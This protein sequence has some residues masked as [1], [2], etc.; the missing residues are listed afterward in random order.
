ME[1]PEVRTSLCHAEHVALVP[2]ILPHQ[3]ALPTQARGVS[4]DLRSVPRLDA[5]PRAG[6][7]LRAGQRNRLPGPGAIRGGAGATAVGRGGLVAGAA[8]TASLSGPCHVTA[9]ARVPWLRSLLSLHL[10][11]SA[12]SCV[13]EVGARGICCWGPGE[14]GAASGRLT[15]AWSRRRAAGAP[16]E[17]RPHAKLARCSLRGA[18]GCARRP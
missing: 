5:R 4:G 11:Q 9:S 2:K 15:S 8:R 1:V 3:L 10:G 12:R 7:R 18:L 17:G 16:A 14:S 13:R 6:H